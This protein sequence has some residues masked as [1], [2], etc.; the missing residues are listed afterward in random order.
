DADLLRRTASGDAAAFAEF[1]RRHAPA[2]F[3]LIFRIIKDRAAAED[4]LQ[5]AFWQS[6]RSAGSYSASRGSP[7][8]WLLLL[9]R[10][11][12]LDEL[13]RRRRRP[14]APL[15]AHPVDFREPSAAAAS[16][17]LKVRMGRALATLPDEQ[18]ESVVLAFFDGLTH[19]Q[20]A[21]KQQLPLG[22]VKSRIRMGIR[23]L[24]QMIDPVD[25]EAGS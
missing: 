4:V 9:V 16:A 10:S 15:D 21:D 1:Y 5:L 6:W 20:I 19:Q 24:S 14:D 18:R 17:E 7:R 22:T 13:R 23:R 12:T 11:R 8:T 2:A 25:G 3:G